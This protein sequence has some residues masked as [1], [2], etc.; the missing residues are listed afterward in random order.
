MIERTIK[1]TPLR[2]ALDVP[3]DTLI[4]CHSRLIKE[5]TQAYSHNI[6]LVCYPT[7]GT[8]VAYAF[9][10][11]DNPIYEA[12][13]ED[14]DREVFAGKRFVEWMMNNRLKEIDQ[15][16]VG[17]LVLYL[18]GSDWKHVGVVTGSERVISQWGTYP[19]YEHD[20]DEVPASYGELVRF[21]EK[22]S[23]E[24]ALSDFLD[25]ARSEGVSNED[26]DAIIAEAEDQKTG[27]T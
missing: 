19:I 21:F 6:K 13:R 9:E 12:I 3:K 14:F 23:P 16:A 5:Q 17:S 20:L 15:P 25:Y 10:L 22:P 1:T 4:G 24:Q 8:C 27:R 11:A 7:R 2:A 26:I 18:L